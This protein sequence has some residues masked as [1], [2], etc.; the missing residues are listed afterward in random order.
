LSIFDLKTSM[1]AHGK[2]G[3]DRRVGLGKSTRQAPAQVD[4]MMS[5]GFRFAQRSVQI[6]PPGSKILLVETALD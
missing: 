5:S 3:G 4:A 6:I 2:P 1:P